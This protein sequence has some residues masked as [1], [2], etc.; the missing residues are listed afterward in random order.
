MHPPWKPGGGTILA[1]YLLQLPTVRPIQLA[2]ANAI[3]DHTAAEPPSDGVTFRV[4]AGNEKLFERHTDSKTWL[5][6]EVD[7]SKFAGR[8]ILL[9]LESHPGPKRDTTCDSSY[10][11]EPMVVAGKPPEPMSEDDKEELRESVRSLVRANSGRG[12][13][14]TLDGQ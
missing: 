10:W 2:F 13:I 5:D 6:A 4:W 9:R 8:Q 14:L 1:E 12:F 7:L 11:G 3:R